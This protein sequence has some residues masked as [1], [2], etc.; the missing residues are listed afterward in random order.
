MGWGIPSKTLVNVLL[1]A[2]PAT[3]SPPWALTPPLNSKGLRH[4][5]LGSSRLNVIASSRV[6]KEGR[7]VRCGPLQMPRPATVAS[8]YRGTAGTTLTFD[9]NSHSINQKDA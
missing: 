4:V 9:C 7:F 8:G 5:P 2:S 6:L 1:I 3:L